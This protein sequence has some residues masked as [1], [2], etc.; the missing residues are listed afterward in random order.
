MTTLCIE[1]SCGSGSVALVR[2]ATTLVER[3]YENPRGRGT[4]LFSALAEVVQPN[5]PI[6]LVLIGSGPGSYNGLRSAMAA[7]RGIARARGVPVRGVCSLLGY[8]E[9][10][11]AIVGDAR[12]GQWF[13]AVVANGSLVDEPRLIPYGKFPFAGNLPVFSPSGIE[14]F[15]EAIVKSP[16]AA[17]LARYADSAGPAVPIYLKP[18]H[19]TVAKSRPTPAPKSEPDGPPAAGEESA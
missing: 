4:E 3:S 17:L 16:S 6:D 2:S 14:G 7:G 15:P 18:P 19:I 11:Y 12:A 9:P 1:S 8:A 13:L 5:V 10:N